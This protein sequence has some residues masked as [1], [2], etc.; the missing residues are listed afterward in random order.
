MRRDV[1]AL[2]TTLCFAAS[3]VVWG[4]GSRSSKTQEDPALRGLIL[5]PVFADTSLRSLVPDS[6][7]G[8]G[9]HDRAHKTRGR[10]NYWLVDYTWFFLPKRPL[11][12]KTFAEMHALEEKGE[13]DTTTVVSTIYYRLGM[14]AGNV[15]DMRKRAIEL[16]PKTPPPALAEEVEDYVAKHRVTNTKGLIRN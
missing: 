3:L 13:I 4:C 1:L 5:G 14:E 11:E 16:R 10:E 6:A 7:A 15:D 2:L 12:F 8:I 9:D